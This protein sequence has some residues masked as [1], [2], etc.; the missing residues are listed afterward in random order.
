[1]LCSRWPHGRRPAGARKSVAEVGREFA[2]E[3]KSFVRGN[4]N[5][6]IADSFV[7]AAQPR[8]GEAKALMAG[9]MYGPVLKTTN[10]RWPVSRFEDGSTRWAFVTSCCLMQEALADSLLTT[11][12][13]GADFAQTARN[14]SVYDATAN[15]GEVGVMPFSAFS[16][17][18]AAAL[19]DAKKGDT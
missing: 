19:A 18:F 7:S 8:R 11:L 1:M 3:V 10:G 15:G 13:N 12:R 16:G 14:Y 9:E 4:R 6:K 17:E 5:G 2:G